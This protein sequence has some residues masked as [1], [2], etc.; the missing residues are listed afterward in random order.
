M[1]KGKGI[2]I[3]EDSSD[4][5]WRC[6]VCTFMNSIEVNVCSICGSSRNRE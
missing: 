2:T 6:E 1:K 5:K 4:D 3:G